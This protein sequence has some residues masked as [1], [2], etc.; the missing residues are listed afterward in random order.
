MR[1]DGVAVDAEV[2]VVGIGVQSLENGKKRSV[3]TPLAEAAVNSLVETVPLRN[4]CPGCSAVGKP[5]HGIKHEPVILWR[6]AC[7]SMGDHI[8]D[9]IP[10][11]IADRI[12]PC[13]HI[14]A[15]VLFFYSI[16][17]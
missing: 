3:I 10:L 7:L 13:R 4:I 15:P 12:A 11:A 2:F 9:L 14:I 6:S 17:F 8:L 16:T 5:Q 1:L